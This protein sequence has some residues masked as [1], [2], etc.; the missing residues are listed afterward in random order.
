M[1]A[2]FFPHANEHVSFAGSQ[3]TEQYDG[4]RVVFR[5]NCA[6]G[7]LSLILPLKAK[8]APSKMKPERKMRFLVHIPHFQAVFFVQILRGCIS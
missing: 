3:C 8:M 2:D 7:S 4:G 6:N 1:E 5:S